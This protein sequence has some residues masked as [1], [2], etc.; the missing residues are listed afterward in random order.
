MDKIKIQDLE[1]YAHHGVLQEENVLGQKFLLTIELG[2]ETQMAGKKDELQYSVSYADVAHFVNEYLQEHTFKL[3]EAVAE[4]VAEELL[5]RFPVQEASVEVKKP[6]APILLPM[7]TVAVSIQRKWNTAYLSIGSNIGD[8][9]GNLEQAVSMLSQN[10][11]IQV[12]KISEFIVTKPYGG[13]EQD[14]FLNGAV[15]IRT[16]LSP[17]E[18]LEAIGS[19]ETALKRERV[20]HW[21]PRTIDLD[22]LL[23]EDEVVSTADLKIPHVEM[24]LRD[25]VL[26]PLAEIAPQAKHPL[27][28]KTVYQLFIDLNKG[29]G[30]IK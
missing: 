27:L 5:I 30:C 24:H 19:I 18:L 25:F 28:Q 29:G 12:E 3:I 15:E 16:L 13:V 9:R 22:I 21:G 11:R 17:E 2:L 14:D 10:P 7:E 4:H 20:I 26:R 23:Y 8:T 1:V 6:W